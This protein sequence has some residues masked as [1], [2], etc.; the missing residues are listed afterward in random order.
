MQ[1]PLGVREHGRQPPVIAGGL[2][3]QPESLDETVLD[4]GLDRYAHVLGPVFALAGQLFGPGRDVV[5]NTSRS[6]L[7]VGKVL[8]RT[9]HVGHEPA[10]GPEHVGM[11][12]DPER[13]RIGRAEA[14]YP[15][16][17]QVHLHDI[18]I[19]K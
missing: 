14:A 11:I 19:Q 15:A 9:G 18:G 3:G 8:D 10:A 13:M 17:V 2:P 5:E 4:I 1:S 16:A 7:G 6:S 12:A